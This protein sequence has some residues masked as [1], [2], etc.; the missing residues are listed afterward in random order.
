MRSMHNVL[1]WGVQFLWFLFP[2]PIFDV[3]LFCNYFNVKCYFEIAKGYFFYRTLLWINIVMFQ[4]ALLPNI[5]SKRLSDWTLDLIIGLH[6]ISGLF[7]YP[8]SGRIS[9]FV[10]RISGQK[11]F[12]W[13]ILSSKPRSPLNITIKFR[14]L[15]KSTGYFFCDAL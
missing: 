15:W 5:W 10:C 11:N 9:G 12:T 7:W 4:S 2:I 3:L 1:I 6:W 13:Y 8:V 14:K